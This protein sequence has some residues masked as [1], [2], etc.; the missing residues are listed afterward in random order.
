MDQ[1]HSDRSADVT[2][3]ES[4]SRS[5]AVSDEV[6]TPECAPVDS[7]G[8]IAES[9]GAKKIKRPDG[10]IFWV[11]D[12]PRCGGKGSVSITDR[13]FSCAEGR[14]GCERFRGTDLRTLRRRRRP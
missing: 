5:P 3:G 7:P 11:M 12:C 10:V 1:R 2:T 9:V 6:G 4:A 8:S 14:G 13:G